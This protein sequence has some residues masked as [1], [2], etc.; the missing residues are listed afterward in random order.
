MKKELAKKLI[1]NHLAEIGEFQGNAGC[2]DLYKGSTLLEGITSEEFDELE[3]E[4][5]KTEWGKEV[6]ALH[7]DMA[8]T[9]LLKEY[10]K[11]NL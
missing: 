5:K 8:L 7:S 11:N 9:E 2:N 4:F 3:C 6:G 1:L 10:V